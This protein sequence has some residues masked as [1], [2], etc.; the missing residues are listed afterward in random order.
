M[1]TSALG[2]ILA[3]H[4]TRDF[5]KER[6]QDVGPGNALLNVRDGRLSFGIPAPVPAIVPRAGPGGRPAL[7]V[8]VPLFELRH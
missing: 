3:A 6:S 2:L 1:A 7:G 4:W 8:R 5:D